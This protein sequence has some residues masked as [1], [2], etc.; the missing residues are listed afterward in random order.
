M[1]QPHK[2]ILLVGLGI[3][4]V[5]AIIFAL[6]FSQKNKGGGSLLS[7][8]V[9]DKGTC[10]IETKR[11]GRQLLE[12]LY[13]NN[14]ELSFETG[15]ECKI[16]PRLKH[17]SVVIVK[18]PRGPAPV[19]LKIAGLPGDTIGTNANNQVT[20]NSVLIQNSAGASYSLRNSDQRTTVGNTGMLGE[21]QYF[22]IADNDRIFLDST[23]FGPVTGDNILGL[24][25][26]Q[27][28]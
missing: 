4:V 9:A 23:H 16:L 3:L 17:G 13:P 10:V 20:V 12:P 1:K 21:N 26:T 25:A 11:A 6:G 27:D 8:L 5:L 14:T 22:V 28:Q 15:P 19:T 18:T 24:L 7:N 2:T